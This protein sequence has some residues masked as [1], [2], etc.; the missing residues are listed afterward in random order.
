MKPLAKKAKAKEKA[1]LTSQSNVTFN[2]KHEC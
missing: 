1:L 2:F